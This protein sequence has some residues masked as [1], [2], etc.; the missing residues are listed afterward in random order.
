[1]RGWAR[2]S[3]ATGDSLVTVTR[4]FG[5]SGRQEGFD[6]LYL[7]R[8]LET[9]LSSFVFREPARHL[10]EHDSVETVRA[11][12]PWSF[13]PGLSRDPEELL[14]LKTHFSRVDAFLTRL[15]REHIALVVHVRLPLTARPV[16]PVKRETCNNPPWG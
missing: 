11:P 4:R 7:P 5:L 16:L 6:A 13:L 3:L 12:V 10:G 1:M 9:K 15:L 14:E 8:K 2:D